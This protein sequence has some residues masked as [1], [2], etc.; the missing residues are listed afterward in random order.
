MA[1][2]GRFRSEQ[3]SSQSVRTY[4]ENPKLAESPTSGA[5]EMA[6]PNPSDGSQKGSP[7]FQDGCGHQALVCLPPSATPDPPE[8]LVSLR[9]GWG[10]EP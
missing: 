2:P 4:P 3:L 8:P 1:D 9:P 7:A 6:A 10:P 5:V